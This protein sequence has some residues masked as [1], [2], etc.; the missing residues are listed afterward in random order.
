MTGST[1]SWSTCP[2]VVDLSGRVRRR[3]EKLIDWPYDGDLGGDSA[4]FWR[5]L[6]PPWLFAAPFKTAALQGTSASYGN[7][8]YM[9]LPLAVAFFG[10]EAA[11]PAALVFAFDC[12]VQ[13]VSHGVSGDTG[14]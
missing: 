3:L 5:C 13:F 12:T 7:V 2:A 6:P 4:S 8:G 11:V 9:G 14:A 1:C 10:P